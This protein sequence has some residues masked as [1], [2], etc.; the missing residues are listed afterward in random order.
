[1]SRNQQ[2]YPSRYEWGDYIAMSHTWGNH[3]QADRIFVNGKVVTISHNLARGLQALSKYPG[4]VDGELMVWN[5]FL[6]LD[7]QNKVEVQR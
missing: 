5:D 7:Q 6:C 3:S 4:V 2:E 1:M